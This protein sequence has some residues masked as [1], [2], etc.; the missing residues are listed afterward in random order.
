MAGADRVITAHFDTRE[1]VP[2]AAEHV[3]NPTGRGAL[4]VTIAR[5]FRAPPL[6]APSWQYRCGHGRVRVH[7][8]AR[9]G[10]PEADES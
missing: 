8:A 3:W 10:W 9:Y 6:P 1:A 5:R 7:R 4:A 2:L